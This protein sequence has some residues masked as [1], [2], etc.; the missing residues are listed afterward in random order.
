MANSLLLDAPVSRSEELRIER[1]DIRFF[2]LRPDRILLEITLRN[3]GDAPSLPTPVVVAAAPL[4]AFVPWRPLLSLAAPM[5]E[6]GQSIQL[7]TE[8]ARVRPAVLGPPDQVPPRRLLTALGAADD[9]SGRGGGPGALWPQVLRDASR[10]LA[11]PADP[12]ELL[13][14]TNVHWAGNLN[15]FVRGKAVERH[16]AQALRIYPGRLNMAMF[17]LGDGREDGYAFHLSGEGARW[18]ARLYD[19][20]DRETLSLTVPN[21]GK[22]GEREWI[23]VSQQRIMMLALCPPRVCSRGTVGVNV[24]QRSTGKTAVV[25][26]SLDPDAAGP[27]CFVV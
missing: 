8:I 17:V 19:A 18:D 9:R 20:S 21:D 16:L 15:V 7:R 10:M 11:L 4:G 25:E 12:M 1:T 14:R 26:F 24:E 3:E 13:G 6:A 27:G 22:I 5:V 2:N 23:D